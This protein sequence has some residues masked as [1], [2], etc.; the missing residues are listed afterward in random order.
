MRQAVT[1]WSIE[2]LQAGPHSPPDLFNTERLVSVLNAGSV[3]PPPKSD[4]TVSKINRERCR[5]FKTHGQEKE[6]A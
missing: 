4:S 5:Q 1:R 3:G 2:I 6:P